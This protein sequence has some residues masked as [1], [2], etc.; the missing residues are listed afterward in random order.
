M[1]ALP[2]CIGA[3]KK[4]YDLRLRHKH[5]SLLIT[6]IYSESMVIAASLS[7]IQT[8]LQ[9]DALVHKPQL[10]DTFDQA[11]TGCR[12]VYGCLDEEVQALV[13]SPEH[14][15][16]EINQDTFK[17]LLTQIRGQQSALSLLIQGLRMESV[18][19][20]AKLVEDN[21][22]KLDQVVKRSRTLRQSHPRIS[23]VPESI[24]RREDQQED[25][26]DAESIFRST[27]F[28]FDDEV[29]NS[30]AYRRAMATYA[31]HADAAPTDATSPST[32]Q[33]ESFDDESTALGTMAPADY[34]PLPADIKKPLVSLEKTQTAAKP[35]TKEQCDAPPRYTRVGSNDNTLDSLERNMLPHMPSLTSKSSF[36][37]PMRNDSVATIKTPTAHDSSH[38]R[39]RSHSDSF[40]AH[41]EDRSSSPSSRPERQSR[42]ESLG[43][44]PDKPGA[45][46]PTGSTG[47]KTASYTAYKSPPESP[48]LGRKPMRKALPPKHRASREILGSYHSDLEVVE[49][50]FSGLEVLEPQFSGLEVLESQFAGLEVVKPRL[51]V[52][53]PR[54]EVSEPG[55]EDAKSKEAFSK[56][57]MKISKPATQA[58]KP[59]MQ[60]PKTAMEVSKPVMEAYKPDPPN[61]V[62]E[63]VEMH[64][65]WTSLVEAEHKLF[66]RMTK[67]RKMFFDS[68][69]R[70]WPDMEKHIEV[71]LI[72]ERLAALHKKLLWLPMEQMLIESESAVC[73]SA[74]F[75]T[76][77][78]QAKDIYKEYCQNT[79]RALG[80]LRAL[81][82]T[83]PKFAPFVNTLGLSIAYFG[84]GW[85][86]YLKVPLVQLELYIDKLQSLVSIAATL[87][88]SEAKK[89][90][91]QLSRAFD[92]VTQLRVASLKVL[93]AMQ[94]REDIQSLEKRLNAPEADY[95]NRL[96]LHQAPRLLKY[97]GTL[98]MK[99][100][101]R[102]PWHTVHMVLLDNF[103]F[104]G[105]IKPSKDTSKGAADRVMLIDEVS[106]SV[107]L[108]HTHFQLT[109]HSP[110]PSPTSPS[111]CP[112]TPTSSKNRPCSTTYPATRSS[113]SCSSS[114]R[115]RLQSMGA[116]SARRTRSGR[117]GWTISV[118]LLLLL[119][120][121]VGARR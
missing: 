5:A 31:A 34:Q 91:A 16:L 40:Q 98:T 39:V 49:S 23:A 56:P 3:S 48:G 36:L 118:L 18:S 17:E 84:M 59:V 104:W 79:P 89:E 101:C 69:T 109:P 112:T 66:D 116:C 22:G 67:F 72:G 30:K 60:T 14:G 19:D 7:Q 33:F 15:S 51:D 53:T 121:V 64:A 9:H 74:I 6:A 85:E 106:L 107:S 52:S 111:A 115:V 63:N 110:S 81:R 21:S 1:A 75:E 94:N 58:S 77:A 73:N 2:Q 97:Q 43:N 37:T 119:R 78:N 76:W 65:V 8:L 57:K 95:L 38:A 4:L 35:H 10:L 46:S 114:A 50:Q 102:G 83:D 71:I 32:A 108:R 26:A 93:N 88:G 54:L 86:D 92:A 13:D 105:K 20:I 90:V 45:P 25:V 99:L 82:L 87:G 96:V 24:L 113:T 28:A 11:L 120:L 68:V 80:A 117:S 12:V 62:L 47:T 103:L 55:L 29:I 100:K 41:G 42:S 70:E 27:G 44:I 61:K